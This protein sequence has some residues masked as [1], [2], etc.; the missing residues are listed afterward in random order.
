MKILVTVKRVID[1]YVK[2]RIKDDQSGVEDDSSIK[3]SMNPFCEIA[4][5]EA[6]RIKEK[7]PETEVIIVS[8]G[9]ND[10]QET[11]RHGLALGADKA[12]LVKTEQKYCSLNYAKILQAIVGRVEPDLILMGKQSIDNDSNQTPQMLAALLNWPQATFASKIALEDN[13][14][15]VTRELDTGLQ[16]LKL[17]LPAVISADLR[18]NEPR[19]A[20]LPNIMKSKQKPLEIL[21]LESLNVAVGDYEQILNIKSPET[22]ESGVIVKSVDELLDKL[23]NEA[24]VL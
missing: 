19:Y 12:L 22:R 17:M 20:T 24:K 3:H 14:V 16:T 8:I 5:E 9:N 1:A 13:H 11:L 10:T 18:L 23:Q 7:F 15:F 6:L 4:L 2:I 21:Q